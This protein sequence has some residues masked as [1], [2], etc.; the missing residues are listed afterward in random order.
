MSAKSIYMKGILFS[1]LFSL[2]FLASARVFYVQDPAY[3]SNASDNNPGTDINR[4][5][6]TWQRAFDTAMAGDTVYFRGGT[7]YP[8]TDIYGNV[9]MHDPQSH[10]GYHGTYANPICFLAYPP[11]VAEGNMPVLD[12]KSTH[13]STN[14]HVGLYI[15]GAR[16]VKFK[17]LKIT[18]VRSW[19]QAS[20]EMWC[21]GIMAQTV[22]HLTLEQMTTS[23]IGGVG[24]M[25]IGHDTLYLTN[26]DAHNNC[27]S[28]D[29]ALPGNDADGY[30]VID[31]GPVT[32]TF[33][34]A[35]ITGCRAWQNSDDGFNIS[36]GNQLDMHD[37][38]AWDN[39]DLEGDANG[40]KMKYSLLTSTWK[41]KVYNCIVACND[42]A[43]IIDLNL[44]YS[45]GPFM[46][47][48]NNS[49]YKCGEGF[50]SGKGQ[51]F[52][53]SSH[54]AKAIYR[55]NI[56]FATTGSYPAAFK[57][58]DYGYPSYIVQDHNTWVQT[59]QLFYSEDN[60]AY[61]VTEDDFVSLDT[62]QLRWPR[63]VDG[64]L[65]DITFMK[66]R[67]DSDLI[68]GGV[69]VGLAYTGNA[70]DLGA[71][72][73]SSY[74]I[75]VFSPTNF[76]Q[77]SYGDPI[78]IEA[79][80]DSDPDEIEEV[81]FYSE[82][83]ERLLGRGSYT[84][85]SIW[86]FTWVSDASRYQNIRG[87]AVNTQGESVISSVVT[88][89]VG[90]PLHDTNS[91][92]GYENDCKIIPNPNNG[93]FSLEL[94]EPLMESSDI[95]IISMMGQMVAMDRMDQDEITKELDLSGLPPGFYNIRF[96]GKEFPPPC[97]QTLKMVKN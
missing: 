83:G 41:R 84:G 82:D 56:A 96:A 75:V 86:Q 90:F 17:G 7:W 35:Y 15:R 24:F 89:Q 33:K 18:N 21:A 78:H 53:C 38:W 3:N 45:I 39:G 69:D 72:Q 44:D 9:T 47:Y 95:Q 23:F 81:N 59:G 88:V 74:S 29:V 26:C 48:S 71:Y 61:T 28:L 62:S 11:D 19:P 14:N 13:P 10:H 40:F 87:E 52:N 4:P 20:G 65:P 36:T 58:C 85:S 8:T 60:P 49:V 25:T 77:Y 79:Y 54:P 22:P 73:Q 16:Y 51:M 43:G 91:I 92:S 12:C 6:A 70:P 55:N 32:D 63:K 50:G 80:V 66:L 27:D 42:H 76:Q 97:E 68:D 64:S 34:I 5:W 30:T 37:C 1:I 93:I 67:S 94:T 2:S 46:E 31:E 57:A